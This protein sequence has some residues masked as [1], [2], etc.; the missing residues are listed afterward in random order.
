M[1][2][3][4]NRAIRFASGL[5]LVGAAAG[6]GSQ[7][8]A[9]PFEGEL[10]TGDFGFV[11]SGGG[12]HGYGRDD[13]GSHVGDG[14]PRDGGLDGASP[15]GSR[16]VE[17]SGGSSSGGS[18]GGPGDDGSPSDG[19]SP[20]DGGSNVSVTF[21]VPANLFDSLD[22]VISGPGGYYSGTV[23][24]GPQHSLEFVAGGIQA[25]SG[26][27]LTLAGD[28]RYG[29]SCS[30]TSAPFEVFPGEVSGATV[31]ITCSIPIDGAATPAAVMTGAVGVDAG[32]V[33]HD[34]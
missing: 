9:G 25:G 27:T 23:Q 18:S 32:V 20:S 21:D 4:A 14:G 7:G 15:D 26:Y 10:G 19:S 3:A 34:M 2:I 28:D 17:D 12:G 16:Q 29:D 33:F 6:C 11:G 31:V 24:F 13:G 30:G 5:A 1:P 22:W 8:A